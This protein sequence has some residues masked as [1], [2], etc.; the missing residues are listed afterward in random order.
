MFPKLIWAWNPLYVFVECLVRYSDTLRWLMK[1]S[2][3]QEAII[4]WS[5]KLTPRAKEMQSSPA[6]AENTSRTPGRTP[7]VSWTTTRK[8]WNPVLTPALSSVWPRESPI[9]KRE[10]AEDG[11]QETVL[12]NQ[13][14]SYGLLLGRPEGN[15]RHCLGVSSL[16]LMDPVSVY[17]YRFPS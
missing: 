13:A 7:K 12:Q 15:S 8:I 5:L 1:G 2:R 14:A 3:C 4:S 11:I 6:L 9:A 10:T 17:I 16:G